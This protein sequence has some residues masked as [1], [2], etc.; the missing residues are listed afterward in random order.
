MLPKG[1]LLRFPQIIRAA[2]DRDREAVR[3]KSIEMKFLTGYEVKVSSQDL[4][5]QGLT[6]L[7]G[8]SQLLG[9]LSQCVGAGPIDCLFLWYLID[10]WLDLVTVAGRSRCGVWLGSPVTHKELPGCS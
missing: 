8:A 5:F 9:R 2:A 6:V 3:Q 1:N 10:Q 7:T 4:G